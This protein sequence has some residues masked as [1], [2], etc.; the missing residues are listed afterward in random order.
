MGHC[1]C[2]YSPLEGSLQHCDK[3]VAHYYP[4]MADKAKATFINALIIKSD[5]VKVVKNKKSA[6]EV[7]MDRSMVGLVSS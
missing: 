7:S 2:L 4:D 5:Q 6:W 1:S 3:V